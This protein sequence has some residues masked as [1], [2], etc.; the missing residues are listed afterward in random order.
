MSDQERYTAPLYAARVEDLAPAAT[1][2][3]SCTCGHRAEVPVATIVAKLPGW[4]R[5]MELSR[6]MRCRAC[7]A[8]G[9]GTDGGDVRVDARR[10]LGFLGRSE[11]ALR[12]E[13]AHA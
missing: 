7:K 6:V 12:V 10:A 9:N 11:G 5:V 1:V 13:P 4:Y 2:A 3:V 8:K